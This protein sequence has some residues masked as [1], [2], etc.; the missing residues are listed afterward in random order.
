MRFQMRV[1]TSTHFPFPKLF[2]V[3]ASEL[4][5]GFLAFSDLLCESLDFS[6]LFCGSLGS[7]L[8]SAEFQ[9]PVSQSPSR[10]PDFSGLHLFYFPVVFFTSVVFKFLIS[11]H[12]LSDSL[13]A[14]P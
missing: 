14:S 7:E 2:L 1:S 13:M 8:Q 12:S 9:H 10:P 5:R 3:P 6:D 4:L 11:V